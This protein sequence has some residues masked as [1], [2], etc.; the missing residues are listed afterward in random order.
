MLVRLCETDR[1]KAFEA[2]SLIERATSRARRQLAAL[3]A[4]PSQGGARL[5]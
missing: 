4:A 1:L 2:A 5:Y 3:T